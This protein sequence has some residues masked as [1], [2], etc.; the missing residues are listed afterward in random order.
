VTLPQALLAILP[1]ANNLLIE[2]LKNTSLASLITISEMTFEG[3]ILRSGTLRTAEI[4]GLLLVLYFLV[5]SSVTVFMRG[6]ERRL[7]I[8]RDHGGVR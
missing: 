8:G 4:F 7:A 2:L 1:P 6:L 5:A 3:Q